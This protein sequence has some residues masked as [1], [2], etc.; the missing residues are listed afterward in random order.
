MYG[1]MLVFKHVC[2]QVFLYVY[3]LVQ[4][5]WNKCVWNTIFV[6]NDILVLTILVVGM[7]LATE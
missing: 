5:N 4:N 3:D 1:Y 2:I 7:S 6:F